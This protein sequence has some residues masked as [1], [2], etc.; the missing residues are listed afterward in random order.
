M[1]EKNKLTKTGTISL[2][3]FQ[4]N[5]SAFKIGQNSMLVYSTRNVIIY[6]I[7][8]RIGLTHDTIEYAHDRTRFTHDKVGLIY[9]RIG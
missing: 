2:N 9:D 6:K 8:E 4:K 5:L 3:I 1:S 7:N